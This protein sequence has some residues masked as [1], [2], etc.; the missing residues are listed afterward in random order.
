MRL[1]SMWGGLSAMLMAACLGMQPAA[2]QAPSFKP[3][4]PPG[5][6]PGG[7]LLGLITT[8]IDPS[9]PAVAR[10][11]ARDGEGELVGWDMVDRDRRPYRTSLPGQ[12][13]DEP[14]FMLLPC[15][16]RVRVAPVRVN[17]AD[18]LTYG[19]ALAFFS[20]TPVR[21]VVVPAANLPLDWTMLKQAAITFP[22][23][24]LLIEADAKFSHLDGLA[25][26]ILL[27]SG[28]AMDE[29]IRILP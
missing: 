8:G 12:P 19:K 15:D 7:V 25:N 27:P 4:L 24:R 21:T 23:I 2:A 3:K 20:T 18:G 29:A 14:A 13:G 10:C 22:H 11:L 17:P 26:V 5:R 28:M 1:A 9:L 16:G 6:D